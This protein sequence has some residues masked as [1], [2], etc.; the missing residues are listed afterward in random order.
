M[1]LE[2]AESYY[3]HAS[4]LDPNNALAQRK[5]GLFLAQKMNRFADAEL[6][7]LKALELSCLEGQNVDAATLSQL[8]KGKNK[9]LH[10]FRL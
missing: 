4:Q 7:L 10:F 1:F 6:F 2:R 9:N 3:K 8:V 5:Y